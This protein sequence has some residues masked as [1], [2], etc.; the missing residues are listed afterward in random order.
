[1]RARLLTLEDFLLWLLH[2]LCFCVPSTENPLHQSLRRDVTSSQNA[3]DLAKPAFLE[4]RWSTTLLTAYD[5]GV[6]GMNNITNQYYQTRDS[7]LSYKTA[8]V[9]GWDMR[10]IPH[11][12]VG[13]DVRFLTGNIHV[14]EV[15][16]IYDVQ[17]FYISSYNV[18]AGL[19]IKEHTVHTDKSLPSVTDVIFAVWWQLAGDAVTTLRTILARQL[20]EQTARAILEEFFGANPKEGFFVQYK[21]DDWEFYALVGTP[22]GKGVIHM[23]L[24]RRWILGLMT[25]SKIQVYWSGTF[26]VRFSL[27]RVSDAL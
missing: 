23:L 9:Q 22:T 27:V 2:L 5:D 6:K 8:K 10:H 17:N 20:V 3:S 24:Q 14:D 1:M 21:P 4:K 15:R 11:I 25:I 19:I 18:N 12:R 7:I 13:E 16:A 26:H